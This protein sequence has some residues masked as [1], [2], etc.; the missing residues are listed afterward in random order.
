MSVEITND[1]TGMNG[2]PRDNSNMR[3]GLGQNLD[4]YQHLRNRLQEKTLQRRQEGAA[5][6]RGI[7]NRRG[8]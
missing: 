4:N 5:K 8:K 2:M 6:Q 3:T 1:G 7:K